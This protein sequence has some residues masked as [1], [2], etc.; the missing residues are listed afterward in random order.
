LYDITG[1]PPHLLAG[2]KKKKKSICTHTH[3]HTP[4]R[5]E[6]QLKA[7]HGSMLQ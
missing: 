6:L 3:T 1:G 2:A 7:G 5:E 4:K